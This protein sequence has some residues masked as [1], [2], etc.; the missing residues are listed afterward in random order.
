MKSVSFIFVTGSSWLD[1]LVTSVTGSQW[2]HVALR[3]DHDDL[4]VESLAGR[5][6]ILQGGKKYEDWSPLTVIPRLVPSPVYSEM[7]ELAQKWKIGEISYGYRTCAAIGVKELMG[8]RAGRLVLAWLTAGR[9]ET[10]VCSEMIVKLWRLADPLFMADLEPCLISP[11]E[12]FK[13][14]HDARFA[15]N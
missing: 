9:K 11:D 4:M 14:L 3:F 1:Y 10:L 12:L 13:N 5:G 2:S 6:L 7:L 15:Q 8:Q